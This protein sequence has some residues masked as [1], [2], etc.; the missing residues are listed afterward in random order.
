MTQMTASSRMGRSET[1]SVLVVLAYHV[2]ADLPYNDCGEPPPSA[3]TYRTFPDNN[4]VEY[5]CIDTYILSSGDLVR[6]CIN[7][8]YTGTSPICTLDCGPPLNT[9]YASIN[10]TGSKE[11]DTVTYTCPDGFLVSS[12]NTECSGQNGYWL[13]GDRCFANASLDVAVFTAVQTSTATLDD[14][15]NTTATLLALSSTSTFHPANAVDPTKLGVSLLNGDCS[16]TALEQRPHMNVTLGDHYDVYQVA[17]TLPDDDFAFSLPNLNVRLTNN[18]SH[19][20]YSC[21]QHMTSIPAGSRFVATCTGKRYPAFGRHLQLEVDFGDQLGMLQI[22]QIEVYARPITSVDCG[23]PPERPFAVMTSPPSTTHYKSPVEW[24]TY[25]CVEGYT[26]KSG[27]EKGYCNVNGYWTVS[28]VCTADENLSHGKPV[29]LSGNDIMDVSPLTDGN[30]SSCAVI[31]NVAEGTFVI[32]LGSDVEVGDVSIRFYDVKKLDSPVINVTVWRDGYPA[33]SC[34][35][36]TFIYYR[37]ET[38]NVVCDYFPVGRY[39][40]VHIY[41]EVLVLLEVCEI[42]VH[43]RRYTDALECYRYRKQTDYKGHLNTTVAGIPC[44][45]WDSQSPHAHSHTDIS[46]FPDDNL[47]DAANYCRNPDGK[48]GLWCYTNDPDVEWQYCPVRN[49]DYMCLRDDKGSTYKGL[50]LKTATGASCVRWSGATIPFNKTS[51]FS[52]WWQSLI[53]CRNPI[54][55]QSRPWCYTSNDASQYGLCDI[56]TSCPTTSEMTRGHWVLD[57]DQT[58][59]DLLP[60][61]EC[62]VWN[63]LY[64]PDGNFS[65]TWNDA[66]TP[67]T[68]RNTFTAATICR[69]GRV[70]NTTMQCFNI[71]ESGTVWKAGVLECVHCGS[72]Y[73]VDNATFSI[74]SSLLNGTAKYTCQKGY[75]HASGSNNVKCLKT[76][77]WEI[78]DM[79]CEV[80][81]GTPPSMDHAD[82]DV[83]STLVGNTANYTC[84]DG[85]AHFSASNQVTCLDSGKWDVDDMTCEVNCG[86][87]PSINRTEVSATDGFVNETVEYTCKPGY[88]NVSGSAFITCLDTGTWEEAGIHCEVDCSSPPVVANAVAITDNTT[89]NSTAVYR[90][91]PGFTRVSGST[92]IT[93]LA[94]GVWETPFTEC[95]VD[96]GLPPQVTNTNRTYTSTLINSTTEYTCVDGTA[97]ASGSTQVMCQ[98][99]GS[100][101]TPDISCLVDCGLPPQ[102]TNTNRT[103]T[104]T[105]INSTTEYT[106]VDGTAHHSGSTQVTCQSDGSWTTPDISCLVDCSSPPVVANTVAITDNTTLNSTAVYIC[107]PGFTHVNGSSNITCLKTGVWG[108]PWIECVVDCG[109][110]SHV[111]STN[112]TYN[113][114]LI[115]STTE[116][117]CV[118]GTA[119][120]SGSTEITCQSDGSWTTPDISCLVDC[121]SPPSVLN[122]SVTISGTWVN[123]SAMYACQDGFKSSGSAS[124]TC[125]KNGSWEIP[126]FTCEEAPLPL[127]TSSSTPTE[128]PVDEY[129]RTR[130]EKCICRCINKV[131][132]KQEDI[133]GE[134]SKNL[135]LDTKTLTSFIMSKESLP[136]ERKSSHGMAYVAISVIGVLFGVVFVSDIYYLIHGITRHFSARR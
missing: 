68:Y 104:S 13:A 38:A 3:N 92:N 116:Y 24:V 111:S 8:T 53:Y 109:V 65:G 81:C 72:P 122:A 51:H 130:T 134:I 46:K 128:L 66:F 15:R 49:C 52:N 40:S 131:P 37:G 125:E 76:G 30:T 123:S 23:Q 91:S 42:M 6:N 59:N 89:L 69:A 61:T 107:T 70:F 63:R 21:M 99:D 132:R 2:A 121:G 56:P 47:E 98:S 12:T 129:G 14:I 17:V 119:H 19:R 28:I 80:D 55:S 4:T 110:P 79:I 5:R 71:T 32:D 77:Q 126:S 34:T 101:T 100:W 33:S 97:H 105:L 87:P 43:G 73:S 31:L 1:L 10:S 83:N 48:Y 136:D 39:V 7:G 75:G 22:C 26:V 57:A 117:T 108:T 35:L 60:S 25:D 50:I 103:Y 36:Y 90:C 114:T 112:M 18:P 93:C 95:V 106:C 11:G 16:S 44:Q 88:A 113:S 58:L 74:S 135:T 82:V 84:H 96:C 120:A 133:L 41:Y 54:L 86:D 102:V 118:D 115:N 9:S 45:R 20:L 29:S 124:V 27:R 67:F 62:L 94:T 64:T 78:P 85:Y 127:T